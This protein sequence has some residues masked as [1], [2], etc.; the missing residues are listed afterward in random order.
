[1]PPA[2]KVR[3]SRF[4]YSTTKAQVALERAAHFS[5]DITNSISLGEKAK[6]NKALTA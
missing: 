2:P 4:D 5:K 1:M 6:R 3:K